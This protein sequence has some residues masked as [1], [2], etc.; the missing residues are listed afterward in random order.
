MMPAMVKVPDLD[1]PG[2]AVTAYVTVRVPVPLA[3]DV[4]VI[5]LLSCVTVQEQLLPVETVTIA[6]SAEADNDWTDGESE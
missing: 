4:I 3:P 6:V 2:F 1:A 5:Q